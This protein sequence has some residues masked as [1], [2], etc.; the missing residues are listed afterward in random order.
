VTRNSVLMTNGGRGVS[1]NGAGP[2][3]KSR[4]AAAMPTRPGSL[5]ALQLKLW[6]AVI[7]AEDLYRRAPGDDLA[8]QLK[9]LNSFT[10]ACMAYL[11][12]ISAHGY[13]TAPVDSNP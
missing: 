8:L 7:H 11:K 6:R 9:S 2:Q 5:S 10:Q 13:N 3:H 1:T 12:A 4:R